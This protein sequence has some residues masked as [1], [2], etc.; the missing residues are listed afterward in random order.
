M[1][2]HI[3]AMTP[4]MTAADADGGANAYVVTVH[5]WGGSGRSFDAVQ[6]PA[7][8]RVLPYEMPGHGDRRDEGPWDIRSASEDLA[9]FIERHATAPIP[10]IVVAHSMGGQLSLLL[11]ADHP[12]LLDMEVVIDPAYGADETPADLIRHHRTFERLRERPYET[13][14]GFVDGSRSPYLSRSAHDTIVADVR[15]ANARALADYY[16]SEYLADDQIGGRSRTITVAARRVKPSF[17]IYRTEDRARFELECGSFAS[18]SWG[19]DHGHYLQCEMPQ[20]L[21]RTVTA[22]ASRCGIPS[23]ASAPAVGQTV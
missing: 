3:D 20:R 2:E 23:V 8:W 17:G 9:R 4:D 14:T 18:V 16:W 12:D 21:S 5:G 13:M 22:W 11:N 19:E 6:W 7:G 1:S 10:V 15:R